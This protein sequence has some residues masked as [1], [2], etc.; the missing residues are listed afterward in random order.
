MVDVAVCFSVSWTC[1]HGGLHAQFPFHKHLPWLELQQRAIR[2][3][4][5]KC[6]L[7]ASLGSYPLEALGTWSGLVSIPKLGGS[8][9]H[10]FSLVKKGC[11]ALARLVENN[12]G[13]TQY[14]S[15]SDQDM[16]GD[17]ERHFT[18]LSVGHLSMKLTATHCHW[19]TVTLDH[20]MVLQDLQNPCNRE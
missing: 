1:I 16:T 5:C 10:I 8:R 3:L 20:A 6:D 9:H 15:R 4:W 11:L 18:G 12:E 14:P 7:R 19:L 13:N 2:S 17:W